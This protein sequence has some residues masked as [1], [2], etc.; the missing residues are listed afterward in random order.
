MTALYVQQ[1]A[2]TNFSDEAITEGIGPASRVPL[3]FGLFFFDYDLDGRLDLLT[4]NGHLEE[5]ISKIQRSQTYKQS[6]QLF[7]NAGN[8]NGG[9]FV[10]VGSDKSGADLF[11]PIV[12][13]GSAFADIDSDGDLDVVLTQAGGPPLLLRN[14]QNL[15]HHWLRLKLV[16]AKS[17]RD[18]IGA[19][20]KVR[21]GGQTLARQVMPTRS[22]LS[23]SELPVTIGLGLAPRPDEVEIK[24]P[25]GTVQKVDDIQAGQL[26]TVVEKP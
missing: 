6:A 7:W 8:Q 4:A 22:Y 21:V 12:G 1:N 16:G 13:R 11:E 26:T 25:S 2:P 10:A 24:W 9:S 14:D 18:A 20:I 15:R 23:Q 5:E 3:K 19:W 17:N